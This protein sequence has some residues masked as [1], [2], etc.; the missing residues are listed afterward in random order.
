MRSPQVAPPR[1]PVH[2]ADVSPLGRVLL[3]TDGTLTDILEA[4]QLE[5][6]HLVVLDQHLTNEPAE[7][8]LLELSDGE[9][10]IHRE[11]VLRGERS[12]VAYV[13][14]LSLIALERLNPEFRAGLL[15]GRAPIGRLW[16]K[17]RMETFKEILESGRHPAG[18][19]AVHLGLKAD[20]W[21]LFRSYRVCCGGRPVMLIRETFR[22]RWSDAG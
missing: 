14:A 11:I 10:A 6:I 9:S 5:P 12:G 19:L 2:L 22:D 17:L 18:G 16:T 21:V 13:H 20:T 1:A 15:S 3:V 7:A 4:H 8:G